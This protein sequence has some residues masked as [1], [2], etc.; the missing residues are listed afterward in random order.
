MT[1]ISTEVEHVALS[2]CAQEEKF[3]SMFLGEMTEVEKP[4]VIYEDNQG[5][6]FLANNRQVGIRT[7]P[8]NIHN[9]FLQEMAEEKDIDIQYIRSEVNPAEIMTENTSE[10][11]FA[12]HMRRIT[13]GEL[14]EL[15]DTGRENTNKTGV[16]D[17]VITRDKTEYSSHALADIVNGINSNE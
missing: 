7:K 17:G 10:A 6:I 15:V 1:I 14:W 11:D 9:H 16:M 3:V 13:E 8:I 12:R 5:K 2:A 4:S